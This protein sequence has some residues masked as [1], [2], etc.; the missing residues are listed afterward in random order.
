MNVSKLILISIIL[1]TCMS[2]HRHD[3]TQSK[4]TPVASKNEIRSLILEKIKSY[5][6]N[7][8]DKGISERKIIEGIKFVNSKVEETIKSSSGIYIESANKINNFFS[9]FSN[10][11]LTSNALN[12]LN[13][14]KIRTDSSLKEDILKLIS[15]I[16]NTI[17]R[18]INEKIK[19]TSIYTSL[20]DSL[21][22]IINKQL[23]KEN[24]EMK[25]VRSFL[26][27]L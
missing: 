17:N 25:D 8:L 5:S 3:N 4:S 14:Q 7:C 20:S 12:Y 11:V 26:N 10:S 21:E 16:K 27:N 22:R 1:I 15:D 9:Y 23:K 13:F 18:N 24:I 6:Q 2:C 19:L